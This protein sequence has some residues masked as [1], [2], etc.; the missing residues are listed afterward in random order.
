MAAKTKLGIGHC[1]GAVVG[2]SISRQESGVGQFGVALLTK[3]ELAARLN[4]PSSRMVDELV[5]RRH[6]PVL[7]LG[8]K[9]TRFDWAKVCAA[10][11]KLEIKAVGQK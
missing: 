5:R 7:R 3:H 4:L 2:G 10:L 11:E 8:H 6:I 1:G 9:T